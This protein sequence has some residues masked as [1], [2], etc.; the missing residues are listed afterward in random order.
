MLYFFTIKELSAKLFSSFCFYLV[1]ED[2]DRIE[3]DDGD[4]ELREVK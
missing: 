4:D 1:D 2:E 3:F